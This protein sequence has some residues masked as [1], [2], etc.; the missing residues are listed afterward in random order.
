MGLI[1]SETKTYIP[2]GC[3]QQ[4]RRATGVW[5]HEDLGRAWRSP[6]RTGA[7]FVDTYP[8]G[9]APLEAA[10]AASEIDEAQPVDKMLGG[11]RR[12]WLTLALV[13]GAVAA[14][15][16]LREVFA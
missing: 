14:A 5:T 7:D 11:Y 12:E 8:T 6:H 16:L 1:M 10:H 15:L 2:Q 4:G 13:F 3:D 9:P